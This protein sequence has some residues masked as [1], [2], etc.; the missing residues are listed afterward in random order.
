MKSDI[1]LTNKYKPLIYT[2]F[3]IILLSAN[4]SNAKNNCNEIKFNSKFLEVNFIE[5]KFDNY[6]RWVKNGL[7]ILSFKENNKF[8]PSKYKKRF[9]ANIVVNYKDKNKCFFG[10]R[11]RQSGD[12]YDHIKLE[13]GNIFQSLDV[14]LEKDNIFGATKFKLFLPITR[15]NENEIFIT[16]LLDEL[17]YLSPKTSFVKIKV[18][19]KFKKFLFQE[20]SSKELV[21]SS[22]LY[23]EGINLLFSLKLKILKPFF[24]H[25]L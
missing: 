3:L 10:A 2:I 17:G 6:K 11:V 15:R 7:R 5:I 20:K 8:I 12:Y 23:F 4:I 16:T 14:H 22:F 21:E 19:G 25:L 1:V 9:N 13:S 24:T 18:N